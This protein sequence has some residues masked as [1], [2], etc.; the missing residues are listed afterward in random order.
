VR[1]LHRYF[2]ALD[3][4]GIPIYSERGPNGGFSLVRGYKM[5][6]LV[7][8]PEEAVALQL[9]ADLVEEVWGPFYREAALG[10]R[11][12]L[13]NL[14]PED[15]RREVAWAR[16][17]LVA[18][19][20][21]R[22]DPRLLSG[23]LDTLRAAIRQNQRLA[24]TY[25]ASGPAEAA[26]R[27]LDPYAL[28]HRWGWW[29]VV[30]FCHLRQALRSFRVDRILSIAVTGDTFQPDPDFTIHAFL[31]AEN[32]EQAQVKVRLRFMPESAYLVTTNPGYWEK[33]EGQVDGS[34]IVGF[35]T[36][37]LP[38]AAANVLAYGPAV[39]ALEPEALRQTVRAWAL[40][41]AARYPTNSSESSGEK[42][43][44]N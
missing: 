15:Q 27:Q 19:G 9:G 30:G 36:L 6:P 33:I 39:E 3:D 40:A 11:A 41:A 13:D 16:R 25:R 24:I 5:P 20:L 44:N 29:Y 31:Q 17:S 42:N 38:G 34:V 37:D 1:T 28:V 14:L 10:A 32:Q 18:T 26:A 4:M 43:G 8:T 12:K 2:G 7:L 35:S 22:A 21:H 23:S